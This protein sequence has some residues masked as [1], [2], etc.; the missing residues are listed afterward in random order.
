MR[1]GSAEE[2]P[3][4]WEYGKVFHVMHFDHLSLLKDFTLSRSDLTYILAFTTA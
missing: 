4:G 3:F 1:V 2:C